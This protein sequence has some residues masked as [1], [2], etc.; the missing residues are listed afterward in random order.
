MRG[1]PAAVD[2][3]VREHWE[4]VER[5]LVRMFGRRQDLEDL[6]QA[7]FLETLHALPSFR[8]Q[9]SVGTFIC[10]IAVR[11][12][13]RARRPNKVTRQSL[14]LELAAEPVSGAGSADGDYER[15]EALRRVQDILEQLSEPKRM[16]FLLW[17]VEGLHVNDVADAMQASV[18][19]TRSRIFYAQK[20]LRAKAARD[21]Y[22]RAW[23]DTG[24]G[25]DP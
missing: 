25:H 13:L 9:S 1:E 3:F 24:A 18:P 7:T 17:A 23:I 15:M 2:W 11:V 16:A 22:L 20:L 5:L 19:A 14:S 12:G 4:R 6:V 21:P 8:R 10:G